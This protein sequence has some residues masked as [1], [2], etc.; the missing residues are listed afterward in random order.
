MLT[1]HAANSWVAIIAVT[2]AMH[3]R[4]PMRQLIHRPDGQPPTPVEELALLV[5][6]LLPQVG[7]VIEYPA[8]KRDVLAARDHL[9]RV[10]LQVL[11]R[12]HRL[13][14]ALNAAPTPARPKT[15]LAEDETPGCFMVNGDHNG[16]L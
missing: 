2:L 15:L 4:P 13:L 14:R 16:I 12:A 10:Q 11:H 8:V 6:H 5:G 9:Q 7:C 1:S 3:D